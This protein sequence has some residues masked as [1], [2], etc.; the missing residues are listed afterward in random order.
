MIKSGCGNPYL[1]SEP[2]EQRTRALVLDEILHHGETANLCLEVGVLD[3]GLDSVERRSN[4]D[5]GDGTGDR[6]NEVLAPG[7]LVVV[8]EVEEVVLG[9]RGGTEELQGT[10]SAICI[11]A[12]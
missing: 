4:G 11:A 3:T 8:V 7:R 2:L 10:Q 6:R 9:E 12:A 1:R 5:G